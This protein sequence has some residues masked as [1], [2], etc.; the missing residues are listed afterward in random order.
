MELKNDGRN[1][2]YSPKNAEWVDYTSTWAE[3]ISIGGE[4]GRIAAADSMT[5]RYRITLRYR[6][7]LAPSMRIRLQNGTLLEINSIRD[8]ENR[9]VMLEITAVEKQGAI[10]K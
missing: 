1:P 7:D 8:P 6:D 3:V 5:V 10:Q 9:G 4:E 2:D